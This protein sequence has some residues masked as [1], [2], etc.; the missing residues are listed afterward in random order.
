MQGLADCKCT[1]IVKGFQFRSY[2][3]PLSFIHTYP[4]LQSMN[5]TAIL[6]KC[7]SFLSQDL[8]VAWMDLPWFYFLHLTFR[9]EVLPICPL[10]SNGESKKSV[11]FS[12]QTIENYPEFRPICAFE[13]PYWGLDQG[14]GVLL[15]SIF[16]SAGMFM[17]LISELYLQL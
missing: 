15:F 14:N 17:R 16:S 11:P 2:P 4:Q 6:Y 12:V 9:N 7:E 8:Y 10:M 5:T 1:S 13:G 3:L